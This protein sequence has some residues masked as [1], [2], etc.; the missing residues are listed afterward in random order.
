[1]NINIKNKQ[2]IHDALITDLQRRMFKDYN[3]RKDH[4]G[5]N[6]EDYDRAQSAVYR[7]VEKCNSIQDINNLLLNYSDLFDK[8]D[9][10]NHLFSLDGTLNYVLDLFIDKLRYFEENNGE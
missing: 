1:M 7:D 4:F 2:A 3:Q 9:D 6:D 5:V 8:A 10:I